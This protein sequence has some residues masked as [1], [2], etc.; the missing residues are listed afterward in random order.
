M[1]YHFKHVSRRGGCPIKRKYDKVRKGINVQDSASVTDMALLAAQ[2]QAGVRK[3]NRT[4][5]C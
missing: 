3:R 5:I 2:S 4:A 1:T